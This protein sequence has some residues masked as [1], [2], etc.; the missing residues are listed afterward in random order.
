MG[1]S[2]LARG[3][4]QEKLEWAFSL[5]DVNHDGYI[6]RDEMMDVVSAIYDMMGRFAEPSIDDNTT[7]E[8]VDKIFQVINSMLTVYREAMR[9]SLFVSRN[10][11]SQKWTA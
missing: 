10:T 5:Y 8:H 11:L 9:G 7:R 4:V 1:L 3:T 2:V 6:T